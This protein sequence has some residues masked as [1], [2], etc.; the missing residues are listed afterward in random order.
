M[1][2][3]QLMVA[4]AGSITVPLVVLVLLLVFGLRPWIRD[5]IRAEL[6][7]FRGSIE[8]RLSKIEGRLEELGPLSNLIAQIVVSPLK[9]KPNPPVSSRNELLE[10]WER[11]ELEYSES[12]KLRQILQEE[13]RQAEETRRTLIIL[14]LIGLALYA[15][16]RRS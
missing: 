6:G 2:T 1:E 7:D 14:A 3:W 15:L 5:T 8:G 4:I 13:A 10:K 11:G 9:S 16:S 12:L